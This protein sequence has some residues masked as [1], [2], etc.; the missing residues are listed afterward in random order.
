MIIF[1]I[2]RFFVCDWK[3]IWLLVDGE[4]RNKFKCGFKKEKWIFIRYWVNVL[5]LFYYLINMD[6]I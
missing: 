2:R 1:F 4:S 3:Y 5:I 6:M